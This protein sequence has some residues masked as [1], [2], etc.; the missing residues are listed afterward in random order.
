[1]L[2]AIRCLSILIVLYSLASL[3]PLHYTQIPIPISF[4]PSLSQTVQNNRFAVL[5]VLYL[6]YLLI[7]NSF[8]M[9]VFDVY[10]DGQLLFSKQRCYRFP[11]DDVAFSLSAKL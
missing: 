1:M 3:P 5:L 6:G 9:G 7:F 11:T 8:S 4:L 2:K 10:C